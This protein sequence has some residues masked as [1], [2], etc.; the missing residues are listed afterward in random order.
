MATGFG[1]EVG[2]GAIA[3]TLAFGKAFAFEPDHPA[4]AGAIVILGVDWTVT[5]R[6][7]AVEGEGAGLKGAMGMVGA[8]PVVGAVAVAGPGNVGFA[9]GTTGGA[10]ACNGAAGAGTFAGTTG[11]GCTAGAFAL[12]MAAWMA[13]AGATGGAPTKLTF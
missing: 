12:A 8:T 7:G 4:P 2:V 11:C 5:V 1:T 9:V 10:G 13:A 6:G 3:L